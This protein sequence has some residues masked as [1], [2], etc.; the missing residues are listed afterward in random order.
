VGKSNGCFRGSNAIEGEGSLSSKHKVLIAIAIS[1]IVKCEWC[2]AFHIKSAL[3]KGA[4]REKVMEA[5]W[6][7]CMMGGGLAFMNIRLVQKALDD[8]L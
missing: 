7:A 3:D 2:I 5:A 1:V 6:V 8:L 4:T